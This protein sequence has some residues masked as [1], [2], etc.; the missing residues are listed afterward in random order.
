MHE[1]RKTFILDDTFLEPTSLKN[2]KNVFEIRE[3]CLWRIQKID[4]RRNHLEKC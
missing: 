1:P 4:G 2:S 3:A